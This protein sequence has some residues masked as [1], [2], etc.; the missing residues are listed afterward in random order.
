MKKGDRRS[1]VGFYANQNL[2]ARCPLYERIVRSD[3]NKIAG[4]LCNC[5]DPGPGSSMMVKRRGFNDL[6]RFKRQNCDSIDGYRQCGC[7]KN[8]EKL[9]R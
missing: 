8:W 7:Y 9:N 1:K 6:M 3:N 5:M 4:I 2:K